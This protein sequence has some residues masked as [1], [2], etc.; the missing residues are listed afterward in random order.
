MSKERSMNMIVKHVLVAAVSAVLAV[1]VTVALA[2]EKEEKI[3]YAAVPA[4]VREAFE[5]DHPGVKV[6][7]A[8]KETYADGTI[9]YEFEWKDDKGKE[10]EVEYNADGE[11]LEEHDDDDDQPTTKPADAHKGH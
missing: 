4:K 5:K 11:Q 1:N 2:D 9:H 6:K 10:H 8:E 3:D 7:K